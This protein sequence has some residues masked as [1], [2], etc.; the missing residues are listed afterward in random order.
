MS[1]NGVNGQNGKDRPAGK[2]PHTG[3]FLP[4]NKL[5]P[6]NPIMSR[7]NEFRARWMSIARTDDVEKAYRF[8]VDLFQNTK[9]PAHVRLAAC[10]AFLDRTIGKPKESVDLTAT[11]LSSPEVQTA[12]HDFLKMRLA[13]R[14]AVD[15]SE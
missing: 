7:V 1:K 4:G 2:D 8:L 13:E 15:P 10:Q 12:L 11:G 3:R 5:S 14:S 6:G 9:A